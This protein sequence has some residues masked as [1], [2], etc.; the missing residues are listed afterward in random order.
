MRH[1]K[2]TNK[3]AS[4]LRTF[5]S[6]QFSPIDLAADCDMLPALRQSRG[7]MT[8]SSQTVSDNRGSAIVVTSNSRR[9]WLVGLLFIASFINYLDRATI[10]VALPLISLELHLGP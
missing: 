9:W 6:S 10:S 1:P 2:R 5:V 3:A 8:N 4:S 7:A